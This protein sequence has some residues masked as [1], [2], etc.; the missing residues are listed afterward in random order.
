MTDETANIILEQLRLIRAEIKDLRDRFESLGMQVQGLSYLV[1]SAIGAL[2]V[3]MKEVK[4]RLS[5]LE[6]RS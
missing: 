3:D 4:R 5:A 2:V 1:S 6:G